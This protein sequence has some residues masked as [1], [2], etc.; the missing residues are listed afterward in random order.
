MADFPLLHLGPKVE[1][2]K[3]F[4]KRTNFE[5]VQVISRHEIEVRVWERGAGETLACGSGAAAVAVAS[6]LLGFV[7]KKVTIRLPGGTL[8]VEWDGTGEVWLSGPAES[9]IYR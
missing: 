9:G 5:V 6:Q 2:H 1:H 3:I 8:N 7:D 4:P